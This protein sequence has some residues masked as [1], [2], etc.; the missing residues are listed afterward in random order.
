M[1][2]LKI[3]DPNKRDAIVND[4]LK[5]RQ[6]IKESQL[7]ERLDDQFMQRELTK[8]F[9][10]ITDTQLSSTTNILEKLT[11]EKQVAITYPPSVP[12]IEE[13]EVVAPTLIGP[14]AQE[15]LRKFA[16]K[17]ASVDKTYGIYNKNGQF[18]I[19]N[20]PVTIED[21]NITINDDTY[22]GTPGLWELI[23][24]KKPG[25]HTDEDYNNYAKILKTTH[26][27]RQ[28]N[29]PSNPKPKASKS[30]KWKRLI[31]PIWE[32]KGVII[33]PSD[34]NALVKRLDLLMASKAA[35]NTGVRNEI[36]SIC[37]ELKRQGVITNDRYKKI[38]LLL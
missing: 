26:A 36:I 27:M 32:G 13:S 17:T 15:Y 12:A 34:P 28:N 22:Q 19:G 30:E 24:M 8:V 1:S 18:F 25:E 20:T 7:G 23:T 21:D 29:D 37:D 9:K 35:G 16:S 6:R 10:P 14:V 11:P 4:Y 3:A 38:M 5:T 33:L 31:K 2:F